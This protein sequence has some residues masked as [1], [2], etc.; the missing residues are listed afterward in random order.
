MG[1]RTKSP[2]H[3]KKVVRHVIKDISFATDVLVCACETR[4]RIHEFD[5]HKREVR[6]RTCVESQSS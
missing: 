2:R 3:E 4:M 5:Q 1:I 6:D